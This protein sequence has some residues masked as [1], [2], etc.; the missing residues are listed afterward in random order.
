MSLRIDT[1]FCRPVA[2]TSKRG[3]GRVDFQGFFFEAE[4]TWVQVTVDRSM[5]SIQSE[6]AIT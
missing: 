1:F 3:G 4:F 5:Y 2:R 6:A